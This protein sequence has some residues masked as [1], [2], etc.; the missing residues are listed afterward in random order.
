MCS[1]DLRGESVGKAR[2]GHIGK[3]T[4]LRYYDNSHK[5][6]RS[7]IISGD[8][9]GSVWRWNT[10][11]KGKEVIKHS[12]AVQALSEL[13]G[14]I[15]SSDSEGNIQLLSPA[16]QKQEW[17]YFEDENSTQ[18]VVT[19]DFYS[20]EYVIAFDDRGIGRAHV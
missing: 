18:K 19:V 11:G 14:F 2:S 10:S 8:D 16:G 7:E 13:E 20:S 17:F 1:S 3:V 15:V 5:A 6:G 4:H 9:R 12:N